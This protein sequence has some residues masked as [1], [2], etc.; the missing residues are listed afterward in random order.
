M[1]G[2]NLI[3]DLSSSLLFDFNNNEIFARVCFYLSIHISKYFLQFAQ[4]N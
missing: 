2:H 1:A 4:K 3:I